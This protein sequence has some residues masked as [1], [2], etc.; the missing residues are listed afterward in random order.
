MD[1]EDSVGT[2]RPL[3]H[4]LQGG[5]RKASAPSSRP[6][7]AFPPGW[8]SETRTA[9]DQEGCARHQVLRPESTWLSLYATWKAAQ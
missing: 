2:V 3:R 1:S 8:R 4:T 7:T 6:V 5:V 9:Q